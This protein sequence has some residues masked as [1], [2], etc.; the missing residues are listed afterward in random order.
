MHNPPRQRPKGKPRGI[1]ARVKEANP[2][3][4]DEDAQRVARNIHRRLREQA[5]KEGA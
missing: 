1:A 5:Q 4:T 3:A 2:A